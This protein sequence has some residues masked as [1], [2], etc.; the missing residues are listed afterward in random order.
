MPLKTVE[1]TGS[2]ACKKYT[3]ISEEVLPSEQRICITLTMW[4]KET[5]PRDIE[6]T[7]PK[8]PMRCSADITWI[9]MENH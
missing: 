7:A 1:K 3:M 6:I 8:W 4:V 9:Y 2:A 5:A